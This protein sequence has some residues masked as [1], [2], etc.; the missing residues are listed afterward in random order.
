M[1]PPERRADRGLS[2]ALADSRNRLP[3]GALNVG[4]PL[5]RHCGRLALGLA[6]TVKLHPGVGQGI[7]WCL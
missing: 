6:R 2:G 4:A 1:C 3:P 7:P 5:G